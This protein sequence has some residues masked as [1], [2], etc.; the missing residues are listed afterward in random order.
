MLG[1]NDDGDPPTITTTLVTFCDVLFM[2]PNFEFM[3]LFEI[4]DISS[5]VALGPL[6]VLHPSNSGTSSSIRS[7]ASTGAKSCIVANLGAASLS[8]S[9]HEPL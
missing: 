5:K 1:A 8:C 7:H 2:S 9:R 6:D 3:S 4:Y